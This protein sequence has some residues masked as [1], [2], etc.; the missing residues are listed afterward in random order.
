MFITCP[1]LLPNS[2]RNK[3]SVL[4]TPEGVV[5]THVIQNTPEGDERMFYIGLPF[6]FRAVQ[7]THKAFKKHQRV[8]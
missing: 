1:G 3:H 5:K 2:V 8:L 6:P 7:E 4:N